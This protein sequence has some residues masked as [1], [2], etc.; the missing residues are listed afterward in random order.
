MHDMKQ[1]DEFEKNKDLIR[2]ECIG[3]RNYFQQIQYE[4]MFQLK[5]NHVPI[6][7]IIKL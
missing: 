3:D 7:T 2:C 6:E 1:S 5:S 4:S